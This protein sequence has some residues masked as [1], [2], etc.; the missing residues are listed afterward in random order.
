MNVYEAIMNRRT[1]RKFTQKPIS[2]DI[3]LRLVNCG[4]MAAYGA[5]M[6]PLKF[7]V[8]TDKSLLNEIFPHTKWAAYLPDGTPKEDE[9]PTAYI[10]VLGDGNIKKNKAF[11]C[12]AGAAVTNMML[13]AYEEGLGS[14]WLGAIDRAAL[15]KILELDENYSLLY[16]L[17]L[18]YPVQ[19]STAVDMV[20][21]NVK[22]Y[23]DSDGSIKVPKRRLEDVIT[24]F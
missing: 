21:D 5:N 22:Y 9:R 14:C 18:G 11:E 4:R 17:A 12:D 10:A 15:S 16:L 7:A 24:E 20:D 8:I 2:R 6:Q 19:K 23:M 3:L 1:I 13:A